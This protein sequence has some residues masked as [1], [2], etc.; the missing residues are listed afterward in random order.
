MEMLPSLMYVL[1]PIIGVVIGAT[2]QYVFTRVL[3]ERR[4]QQN[5]RTEAYVDFIR[6]FVGAHFAKE[7]DKEQ[8]FI[9]LFSDATTRIGIYGGK[10][11]LEAIANVKRVSAN[12]KKG[13]VSESEF[14]RSFIAIIQAM[15]E[16]NLPK[17]SVSDKDISQ[18]LFGKD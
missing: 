18:S 17:E 2:L 16:E 5:L 6:G 3:E 12:Y 10:E 4:H 11:V 7:K 8:E 1:L 15:R 14:I 13:D 9:S